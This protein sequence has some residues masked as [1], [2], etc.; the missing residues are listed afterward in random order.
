MESNLSVGAGLAERR[1]A[2]WD[3][4]KVLAMGGAEV[5]RGLRLAS[6]AGHLAAVIVRD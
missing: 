5:Y 6:P 4:R 2:A 3:S 1:A